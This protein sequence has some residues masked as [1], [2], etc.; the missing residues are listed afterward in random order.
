MEKKYIRAQN[1]CFLAEL[2]L[3]GLVFS[4]VLYCGASSA[5]GVFNLRIANNCFIFPGLFATMVAYYARTQHHKDLEY[6]LQDKYNSEYQKYKE[7][8]LDKG[9]HDDEL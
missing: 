3:Y 4:T 6:Q 1:R 7:F 5:A 9:Y 2:G 8:F